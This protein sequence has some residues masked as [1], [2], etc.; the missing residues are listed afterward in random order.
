[1]VAKRFTDARE[2][3]LL[4]ASRGGSWADCFR[5][6]LISRG[7]EINTCRVWYF[8]AREENVSTCMR[9]IWSELFELT[10]QWEPVISSRDFGQND[11]NRGKMQ[12]I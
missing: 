4:T 1:M 7:L 5:D 10:S 11:D 2:R 6:D 8:S 9:M 12:T 3:N